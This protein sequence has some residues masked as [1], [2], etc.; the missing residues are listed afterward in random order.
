MSKAPITNNTTSKNYDY[1]QGKVTLRF[2]LRT[3]IKQEMK[4]FLELL[5]IAQ[6]QI[7]EDLKGLKGVK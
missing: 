3:D 7:E 6:R 1:A 5:G 2:S 4:D